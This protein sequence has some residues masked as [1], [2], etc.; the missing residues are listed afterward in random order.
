MIL[1]TSVTRNLPDDK[2]L[3][4]YRDALI[5]LGGKESIPV[6]DIFTLSHNQLMSDP[7]KHALMY[8]N[9]E[10]MDKRFT[11]YPD[12]VNSQ[13][14]AKGENDNT[15]LNKNGARYV[16]RLAAEELK[17]LNHPLAKYLKS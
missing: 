16:S 14:Y 6:L 1:A 11:D 8:M 15:H 12:F 13:Y 17:R 9:L 7:E 2:T 4:P 5:A 10:P 3:F